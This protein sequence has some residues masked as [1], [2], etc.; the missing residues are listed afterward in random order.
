[1]PALVAIWTVH[2]PSKAFRELAEGKGIPRVEFYLE[3]GLLS[4]SGEGS[5]AHDEAH[6]VPD[7]EF[8]HEASIARCSGVE[9]WHVAPTNR[10]S[11][12]QVRQ[13]YGLMQLRACDGQPGCRHP[14][15][16]TSLL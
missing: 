6:N 14:Q 10:D 4:V 9:Q 8:A 2:A 11:G 7:I 13:D 1:M 12:L 3:I 16:R 5:F 15:G